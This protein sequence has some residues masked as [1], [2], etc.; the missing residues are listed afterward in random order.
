MELFECS[1]CLEPER[2]RIARSLFRRELIPFYSLKGWPY[3]SERERVCVCVLPSL[4]AHAVGYEM[5]IGAHNTVYVWTHLASSTVF[6]TEP[7]KS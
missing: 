2:V 4:V 6:V 5:V 7:T 1:D 3:K